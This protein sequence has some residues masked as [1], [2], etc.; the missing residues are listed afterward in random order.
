[1]YSYLLYVCS[2]VLYSVATNSNQT[3][4][5][6]HQPKEVCSKIAGGSISVFVV[7]NRKS[8]IKMQKKC[9]KVNYEESYVKH[10]KI[11]CKKVKYQEMHT[12]S[13]EQKNR[14][15]RC[16]DAEILK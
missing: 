8:K 12:R 14:T 15:I 11:K 7:S 5:V 6:V 9:R 2:V 16:R 1:M 10:E 13:T 4:D 3:T